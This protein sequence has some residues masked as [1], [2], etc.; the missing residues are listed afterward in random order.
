MTNLQE[1]VLGERERHNRR[2]ADVDAQGIEGVII[3]DWRCAAIVLTAFPLFSFGLAGHPLSPTSLSMAAPNLQEGARTVGPSVCKPESTEHGEGAGGS[4]AL[5]WTTIC[6]SFRSCCNLCGLACCPG[7]RRLRRARLTV[8]G[9]S[10]HLADLLTNFL[11]DSSLAQ[12]SPVCDCLTSQTT[13]E[14]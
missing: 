8:G 11:R 12:H 7:P 13:E 10:Q 2:P 9:P 5:L 1:E 3:N 6:G 14:A 4:K